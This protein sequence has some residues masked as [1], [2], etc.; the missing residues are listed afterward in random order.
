MRGTKPIGK[1]LTNYI[2]CTKKGMKIV[3]HALNNQTVHPD[4]SSQ[5]RMNMTAWKGSLMKASVCTR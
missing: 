2:K 5:D 3:L 1:N 4:V